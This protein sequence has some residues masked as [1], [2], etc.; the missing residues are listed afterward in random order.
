MFYVNGESHY[1]VHW[2]FEK[3]T[4]YTFQWM[5]ENKKSIG[6]KFIE[7]IIINYCITFLF[8]SYHFFSFI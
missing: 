7:Q 4:S 3:K 1:V 5:C 2:I 6:H 8:Y